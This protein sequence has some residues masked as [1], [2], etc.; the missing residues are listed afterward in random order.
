MNRVKLVL[1][2]TWLAVPVIV[3]ADQVSK[4]WIIDRFDMWGESEAICG[5]FFRLTRVHN[6]GAAFGIA[7]GYP[8]VFLYLTSI[9]IAALFLHKL[10]TSNRTLLY[11]A[12][13]AC[14]LSGAIGN[15]IDRVRFNYVIDFLDFGWGE[16]RWPA[17]NVAD[18]AI[19]VGVCLLL[20][21]PYFTKSPA[22]SAPA[23]TPAEAA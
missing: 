2:L 18:S 8:H 22:A 12:A 1:F 5:D 13:L 15:L 9:A 4:N 11:Q 19:T 16:T 14:V 7:R 21:A 17:F 10:L 3:A 6:S 23:D 20:A